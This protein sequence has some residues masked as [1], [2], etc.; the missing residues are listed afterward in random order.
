MKGAMSVG[1]FDAFKKKKSRPADQEIEMQRREL[2]RH[3]EI[4]KDCEGL[5][6]NS[7]NFSTVVSRYDLMLDE[8][9]YFAAWE[10]YGVDYLQRYGF[11]FKTPASVLWKSAFDGKAKFLNSAIDRLLDLEIDDALTLKTKSGQEKRMTLWAD[12]LQAVEA[13][14]AETLKYIASLPVLDALRE[15]KVLV[16]CRCGNQ[17]RER[18]HA[19]QN[20][21]VICPKCSQRLRV[22][23]SRSK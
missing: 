20:Y 6:N 17:F 18:P 14:P 4:L 7:T 15:P 19:Y 12:K 9:G 8:L 2:L 21:L 11:T 22:D 16:T 10:A 3:Y 13:V 23:T 1:L 5:I